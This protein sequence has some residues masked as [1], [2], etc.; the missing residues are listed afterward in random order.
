MNFE[1]AYKAIQDF[2]Q[3]HQYLF[4]GVSVEF[5]FGTDRPSIG[6]WSNSENRGMIVKDDGFDIKRGIYFYAMPEGEIV[7]IGKASKSNLHDRVWHHLKTAK[8]EL[9]PNK[10]IFPN[11]RFVNEESKYADAFTNGQVRLGIVTVS[12]RVLV[13][14]LEV[15]LQTLHSK[16]HGNLPVLNKQIG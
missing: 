13:S 9:A 7:Y 15:Y 6:D 8:E 14:L 12:D 2:I 4:F 5:A 3:C 10:K 16:I 11:H 1:Q